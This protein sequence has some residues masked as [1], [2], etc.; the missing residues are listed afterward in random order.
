VRVRKLGT[1]RWNGRST[2]I[3][4]ALRHELLGLQRYRKRWKVHFGPLLLGSL[5]TAKKRIVFNRKA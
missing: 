5:T 4:S 2:L 3:S 1:L